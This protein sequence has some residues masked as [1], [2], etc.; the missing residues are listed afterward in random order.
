[1]SKYRDL[2]FAND[3]YHAHSFTLKPEWLIIDNWTLY[4][5]FDAFAQK[6]SINPY[7]SGIMSPLSDGTKAI[8]EVALSSIYLEYEQVLFGGHV[9]IKPFHFGAETTYSRSDSVQSQNITS[10]P[11]ASVWMSFGSVRMSLWFLDSELKN[12]QEEAEARRAKDGYAFSMRYG[13]ESWELSLLKTR[14]DDSAITGIFLKNTFEHFHFATEVDLQEAQ[15]RDGFALS[16][17]VGGSWDAMDGK[18]VYVHASGDDPATE[19]INEGYGLQ[20]DYPYFYTNY[21]LSFQ[22][23]MNFRL[24]HLSFSKWI[25]DFEWSAY[26][27]LA[28]QDAPVEVGMDVVDIGQEVSLAVNHR[29]GE[30]MNVGGE[31]YF[32]KPGEG[33]VS[34]GV[35]KNVYGFILELAVTF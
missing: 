3:S 19:E 34:H 17:L 31:I 8:N 1:M 23:N 29:F 6:S 13:G 4:T 5:R 14:Y 9:G 27:S 33:L 30:R 16:F 32:L 22:N 24:F 7:S 21:L 15:A 11:S 28:R 20:P 26:W 2:F 10:Y 18:L 12:S 35:L 25:K